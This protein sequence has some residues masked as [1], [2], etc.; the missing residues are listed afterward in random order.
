MSERVS[1]DGIGMW[2]CGL[3]ED[4]LS[5]WAGTIQLAGGLNGGKRQRMNSVLGM[6][7]SFTF[8]WMLELH[9]LLPLDTTTTPA[10]CTPGS[11]TCNIGLTVIPIGIPGSKAL[12]F[13][14]SH[15]NG[16]PGVSAWPTVG[17]FSL[18]NQVSNFP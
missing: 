7:T 2:V 18:P 10:P 11:G 16:F 17:L 4:V 9:I 13:M 8:P 6:R 1:P 3:R 12:R 14:L 5:M 15:A